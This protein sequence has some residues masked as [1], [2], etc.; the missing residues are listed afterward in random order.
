MRR[1]LLVAP[2]VAAGVAS[3]SHATTWIV[4][5][6]SVMG[7]PVGVSSL[8]SGVLNTG[9]LTGP[10]AGSV[11]ALTPG[12]YTALDTAVLGGDIDAVGLSFLSFENGDGQLFFGFIWDSRSSNQAATFT[13]SVSGSNTGVFSNISGASATGATL[14]GI[15]L[16]DVEYFLFA[17]LGA[18]S[19]ITI[20]GS[21]TP[22]PGGNIPISWLTYDGSDWVQSLSPGVV[23]TGA[24]AM[25]SV[26]VVPVPAPAALAAA[27]LAAGL[28]AARRVR[29]QAAGRS[30]G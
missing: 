22:A 12:A 1:S 15:S 17:G 13:A 6:A 9:S 16:D 7:N 19:Q 26:T 3:G 29:R 10:G 30:A 27:G 20:S 5:G 14:T 4:S 2:L 23:S 24:F 28:L 18:D 21:V 8:N 11:G 25:N